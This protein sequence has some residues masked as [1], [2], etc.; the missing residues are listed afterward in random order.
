MAGKKFKSRCVSKKQAWWKAKQKGGVS[1]VRAVLRA[2]GKMCLRCLEN[3]RERGS[4]CYRCWQQRE[5]D[6]KGRKR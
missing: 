5:L 4:R 2:Q 1:L 3:P 6:N